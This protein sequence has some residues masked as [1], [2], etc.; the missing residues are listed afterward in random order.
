MDVIKHYQP[1]RKITEIEQA[2]ARDPEEALFLITE[3]GNLNPKDDDIYYYRIQCFLK[4]KKLSEAE[5]AAKKAV[6]CFGSVD[7]YG[8]LSLVYLI[9]KKLDKAE[10][11]ARKAIYLGKD[12]AKAY[13]YLAQVLL[14]KSSFAEAERYARKAAHLNGDNAGFKELLREI[15]SN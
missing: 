2:I 12:L 8:W 15:L 9:S 7:A 3:A 5:E 1:K 4:L 13:G 10:N 11:I 14:A 6:L